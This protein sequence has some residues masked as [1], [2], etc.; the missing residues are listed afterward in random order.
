MLNAHKFYSSKDIGTTHCK[1]TAISWQVPMLIIIIIINRAAWLWLSMT[2]SFTAIKCY[3]TILCDVEW[4][5]EWKYTYHY[6]DDVYSI[7]RSVTQTGHQKTTF[8]TSNLASTLSTASK[9]SRFLGAFSSMR[10]AH[11]NKFT[12]PSVCMQ[13]IIQELQNV[14]Y[15]IQYLGVLWKTASNIN[16]HLGRTII[17]TTS[18]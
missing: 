8:Q 5:T 17:T 10:N 16:F 2:M 14:V 9:F 18:H 6:S 1:V 15:Y 11:Y 7:S 4:R 3:C 13:L 12:C